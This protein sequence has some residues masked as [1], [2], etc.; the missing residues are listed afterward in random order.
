M[1][2]TGLE[3][4]RYR[5]VKV[6]YFAGSSAYPSWLGLKIV[7]SIPRPCDGEGWEERFQEWLE[8]E[9]QRV[10]D[11]IQRL[12]PDAF[13]GDGPLELE[14]DCD[15]PQYECRTINYFVRCDY[16]SD[17]VINQIYE[18]DLDNVC[19]T[20]QNYPVYNL[21]NIPSDDIFLAELK[22][23]NETWGYY[24]EH[25]YVHKIVPYPSEED[26]AI[27]QEYDQSCKGTLT[28]CEVLGVSENQSNVQELRTRW[29][30]FLVGSH[31]RENCREY[32][33][34]KLE[35][36]AA[37]YARD[38][39]LPSTYKKLLCLINELFRPYAYPE[40]PVKVHYDF[41]KHKLRQLGDSDVY[42]VRTDTVATIHNH[43]NNPLALRT[44]TY[45]LFKTVMDNW[46]TGERFVYGLLFTGLRCVLVRI[47]RKESMFVHS[48]VIPFFF[49][50]YEPG[51]S[52]P[53]I[54]AVARLA[55]RVDVEYFDKLEFYSDRVD[56]D[57]NLFF[58]CYAMKSSLFDKLPTEILQ[59]IASHITRI[60]SLA[61]FAAICPR[62]RFASRRASLSIFVSRFQLNLMPQRTHIID[63]ESYF[64]LKKR[65]FASV[66][67]MVCYD[68]RRLGE[69]RDHTTR[70][71]DNLLCI[72][73]HFKHY[74]SDRRGI[75]F[76]EH[77]N[78]DLFYRSSVG[79]VAYGLYEEI[80]KSE[81][82]QDDTAD[83]TDGARLGT[84]Q[85]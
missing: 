40:Y 53:G 77:L 68:G 24:P 15:D 36:N 74:D 2:T 82:S 56:S 35:N 64:L 26:P 33:E 55:G 60:D 62:N 47:D 57:L 29:A 22:A 16:L 43:L 46:T 85:D 72:F 34:V 79:Q 25:G 81:E 83:S 76:R 1:V 19:F 59:E 45:N 11:L 71:P 41:R 12:P 54:T 10:E 9:R 23:G 30:E 21:D 17:S 78:L 65:A 51:T 63:A 14:V 31:H 70:C 84:E 28:A 69:W 80:W 3:I 13:D 38:A 75:I 44:G 32:T 20:Y 50:E 66:T 73:A 8:T 18:V 42:V 48:D 4:Y 39:I 49:P 6:A 58:P 67:F 7:R 61:I 27:L 52:T 37:Q 5:N